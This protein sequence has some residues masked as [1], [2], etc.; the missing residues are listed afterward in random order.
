MKKIIR[1]LVLL[2]IVQ[3]DLILA[4]TVFSNGTGGG[5]WSDP[6]TWVGN[7][8]PTVNDDVFIAGTDSVYTAAGARCNSLT[9][10]S[11]GRFATSVDTVQVVNTLTL[12][13]NAWCYN[14]TPEPN[15]PGRSYILDPQSYTVQM[16]SSGSVGSARNSEFGN[17]IISKNNGCTPGANLTISGNLI[18]NNLAYNLVF[19][20]VRSTGSQT[21]T[22]YGDVYIRKGILSCIDVPDNTLVG[23]WNI[24]GSVYVSDDFDNDTYLESRIGPFS[25]ANAAGL[26]IINIAGDLILEGGRL[27]A[28]TSSS[29]GLG[30]GIINLEGDLSL[31]SNSGVAT[32]HDGPFS[33][34]FVGSGTQTVNM[35]VRFQMST[36]VYDTVKAGSNVVFDLDTNKWGSSVGGDFFIDGS[37]DLK[38]ESTLD[39]SGSFTL[40]SGGTLK[41]GSANGITA[42]D[43]IGNVKMS[44]TRTYSE[45][46]SYEYKGNTVQSLG[47]GLPGS[48]NG[49]GV[50]NSNGIVLDRNLSVNSSVNIINGDL[51]LNG[52][53]ITLGSNA[54]L[55][56]TAGNTITGSSGKI[57]IT[58]D[59]NAPA[60]DN[61]GGLGAMLTTS[62]NLGSTTIDRIHSAAMG[63]GNEGI[64]RQYIISPANNSG[65]NATLRLYYDESELN[66]IPEDKLEQY[67][68]PDG[69][70]DNWFPQGGTVNT[71]DNYVEKT[72]ISDF[73]YWTLADVDNP[74]PVEIVENQIPTVFALHQNYPNPFNPETVIQFE[75]PEESKVKLNVF[76]VLGELV[77]TVV[78]EQLG[79]GVYNITFNAS[80]LPSGLYIY[81][82]ETDNIQL[83]KKMLLLK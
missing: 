71:T 47:D 63:A 81:K 33:L 1:I 16:G 9:V 22:V 62:I 66:G 27:Q 40:N 39:G 73:S 57:T 26:G 61:V 25:S 14:L 59:I 77:A 49:F 29:H 70:N 80:T 41:I 50:N 36:S 56:E 28:G 6:A 3:V 60:G 54:I 17:L 30:T 53:E 34:N 15:L 44:G 58:R 67:K 13:D 52:N 11:G 35:D 32:N 37:L 69:A 23:I 2:L 68:S 48:V 20:A 46:A 10:L 78:N 24:F 74:L 21:H 79:V 12:E 4:Q 38:D 43:T 5:L 76:N 55:S 82:L 72:G 19:R 31:D 64:F 51:D 18:I 8:V 75:I 45:N 83:S 42:S 7:V 65:L